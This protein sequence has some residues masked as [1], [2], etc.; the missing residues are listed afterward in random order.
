MQD[1]LPDVPHSMS[2]STPEVASPQP[3]P[4]PLQLSAPVVG[5][6]SPQ[7]SPSSIVSTWTSG[8]TP[9]LPHQTQHNP[10][11]YGA[12]YPP[13]P[14]SYNPYLTYNQAMPPP[15]GRKK[16][17]G[18]RKRTCIL[19]CIIVT[20]I[21]IGSVIGAILGILLNTTSLLRPPPPSY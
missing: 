1:H 20:L 19:V 14:A 18:M 6:P 21:F 3:I 10:A 15:D 12:Y 17:C 16:I 8:M 2:A 7:D 5:S 13:P 4:V 11:P 9:I